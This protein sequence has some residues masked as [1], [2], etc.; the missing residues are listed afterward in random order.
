[1]LIIYIYRYANRQ[2]E[3]RLEAVEVMEEDP[4]VSSADSNDD[5]IQND[6]DI[7]SDSNLSSKAV[8]NKDDLSSEA[9][10]S[11][12]NVDVSSKPV[13]SKDSND[14]CS[15]TAFSRDN[16]DLSSKTVLSINKDSLSPETVLRINKDCLSSEIE[17]SKDNDSIEIPSIENKT[18]QQYDSGNVINDNLD[19][20]KVPSSSFSNNDT[21]KILAIDGDE[22]NLL[23]KIHSGSEIN[24]L[25]ESDSNT[26]VAISDSTVSTDTVV[27]N[28]NS[29]DKDN[30]TISSY[31]DE[32]NNRDSTTNLVQENIEQNQN[33]GLKESD[34][35]LENYSIKSTNGEYTEPIEDILLASTEEESIFEDSQVEDGD[36]CGLNFVNLNDDAITIE[37]TI[38]NKVDSTL[39][40]NPKD[41]TIKE[42][43]TCKNVPS[44]ILSEDNSSIE[45]SN[46]LENGS[47]ISDNSS[48]IEE[49]DKCDDNL[50]IV[51]NNSVHSIQTDSEANVRI[52]IDSNDCDSSEAQVNKCQENNS[53]NDMEYHEIKQNM[54]KDDI[55]NKINE[56]TGENT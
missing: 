41:S 56:L 48:N 26:T 20:K 3:L 37:D 11:K 9:I 15:E 23:E 22:L 13:S 44:I 24:S 16:D 1:M 19:T 31:S 14:L 49:K 4:E 12:D 8:F 33:D 52:E 50:E 43:A 29:N 40:E 38:I 53:S 55:I 18:T 36:S 17:L 46:N 7:K 5:E 35:N 28:T 25:S 6:C 51:D 32:D 10:L 30:F 39:D 47:T 21:N 42:K 2:T 27:Q 54:D 45:N 34:S